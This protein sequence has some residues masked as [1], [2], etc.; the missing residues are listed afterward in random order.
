MCMEC[1][2]Q[3][4]FYIIA[5]V[6]MVLF[7]IACIIYM[8]EKIVKSFG[9][10]CKSFAKDAIQEAVKEAQLPEKQDREL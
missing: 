10:L 4:Q 6:T 3:S 1:F 7:G 2:Y 5:S 9:A 8:V